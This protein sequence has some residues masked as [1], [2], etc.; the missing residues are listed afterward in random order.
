MDFFDEWYANNFADYEERCK[1]WTPKTKC[2]CLNEQ[3]LNKW[4]HEI[5][6]GNI[7]TDIDDESII[8]DY[9]VANKIKQHLKDGFGDSDGYQFITNVQISQPYIL[10][11][12]RL[13]FNYLLE[14]MFLPEKAV[15]STYDDDNGDS[16]FII[17]CKDIY[18]EANNECDTSSTDTFSLDF[19]R[20]ILELGDCENDIDIDVINDRLA[21]FNTAIYARLRN[22]INPD[23][24]VICAFENRQIAIAIDEYIEDS[25]EVVGK[26]LNLNTRML[27]EVSG[28][29]S[30][31][32]VIDCEKV[33][34]T[35]EF[36]DMDEL[37]WL[38]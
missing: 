12:G 16:L 34:V 19:L 4:Y 35:K 23:S 30:T 13:R 33:F 17:N 21:E 14:R 27:V 11:R 31:V 10:I 6:D 1:Y 26:L 8:F 9:E 28:P 25:K 15:I 32:L 20:F 29:F 37:E 22:H 2:D 3:D 36:Y 24:Q 38:Y 5:A 18:P 7:L